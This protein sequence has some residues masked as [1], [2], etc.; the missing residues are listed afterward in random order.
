MAKQVFLFVYNVE[1]KGALILQTH[2]NNF[3]DKE[4]LDSN[5]TTHLC[6][7][8]TYIHRITS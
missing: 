1:V 7:L 6:M 4:L 8:I 2:A 3:I 5:E